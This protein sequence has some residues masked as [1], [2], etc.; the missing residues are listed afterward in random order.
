MPHQYRHRP[1]SNHDPTIVVGVS[2]SPAYIALYVPHQSEW[3]TPDQTG[4]SRRWATGQHCTGLNNKA[5]RDTWRW[6]EKAQTT[7]SPQTIWNVQGMP[8]FLPHLGQCVWLCVCKR[9]CLCCYT[10]IREYPWSM[11]MMYLCRKHC[12][13]QFDYTW[14]RKDKHAKKNY[15]RHRM[16][17]FSQ[18]SVENLKEL[19][20]H[21]PRRPAI[22][23]CIVKT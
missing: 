5:H 13:N 15:L 23:V 6:L 19:P 1:Q 7:T 22:S 14:R 11:L 20:H 2:Y 4:L 12:P 16:V 9:M 10:I 3:R 21:L 18:L 17:E 8:Q